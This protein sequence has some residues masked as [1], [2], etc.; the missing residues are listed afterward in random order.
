MCGIAGVWSGCLDAREV[1]RRVS[2][3]TEGL[4]HRGPDGAGVE[5]VSEST[6]SGR[7][8]GPA[9]AFG[10]RRL[11]IID[12]SPAGRQPMR[13]GVAGNWITYNGEIYNFLEL[14]AELADLGHRFQS[15]GDTEVILK[16]YAQWGVDAWKKLRGIFAFGLWD[17]RDDRLHLVRD[18]LGVKPLYYADAE[19]GL[20]FAS[21]VRALLAG[22][23]VPRRLCRD[24]LRSYL[25]Y[26]SVQEPNTLIAGVQSLPPGATLVRSLDGRS[27]VRTYWQI[28]VKSDAVA[29]Q[30]AAP[31]DILEWLKDSVGRQLMADV[32][33]G[34]FLSGG[35]DSTAVAALAAQAQPGNIRTFCIGSDL[36]E[37]DE[38]KAALR[39]AE[40][41]GCRHSTLILEGAAVRKRWGEALS[42]YDQPSADGINT[43]FVSLLVRQ[44]GVMV[45]LSG[46]GGD[47]LF[48]G[49]GGFRKALELDKASRLLGV[50][51]SSVRRVAHGSLGRWSIGGNS[52]ASALIELIDPALRD[53]YFASRIMFCR[54]HVARLLDAR[55][56]GASDHPAWEQRETELLAAATDL[57]P[58]NRISFL[59][60]QT[61]MLST[62]LRDSD[63]M[64]M[65]HGLELRVPLIDH[66]L[67][68]RVLPLAGAQ[69]LAGGVPKHLLIDALQETVPI[70][71]MH[72][73]KRGFTLPFQHWLKHD[74][75][76]RATAIFHAKRLCGPW[77]Q[78]AF[79]RVWLDFEKG[80][81][82]WSRVVALYVLEQWLQEN[83]VA[84]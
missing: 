79:Q 48:G 72:R 12:L 70:E 84:A 18:Q 37:F 73:P 83:R 63:Q 51:P 71:W 32:P 76:E 41:L 6:A 47:E 10:H 46:L 24:G 50:L 67:V 2:A 26:G 5:L 45:A 20:V 74:I 39:S 14:R 1:A 3:M 29:L 58:I 80:K 40:Y 69:K 49:Y 21:E 7:E 54:P 27:K 17:A 11:A 57:D 4:R 53:P 13:D 52:K 9:V 62:L 75:A 36:A 60:L 30:T 31:R 34:V 65:A 55:S 22:D 23:L 38:S 25:R 44:A 28:P 16:A 78:H 81:L 8:Q 68:E 77:N 33:V 66:R 42:S 64:S 15:R 43:Y 19:Q 35:I 59:E 56:S 82:A 61:Y